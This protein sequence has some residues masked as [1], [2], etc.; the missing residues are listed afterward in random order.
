MKPRMLVLVPMLLL[1]SIARRGM[2]ANTI[3]DSSAPGFWNDRAIVIGKYSFESHDY[4]IEIATVVVTGRPIAVNRKIINPTGALIPPE[5]PIDF[6]HRG[7]IKIEGWA[8]FCLIHSNDDRWNIE[9]NGVP[10]LPHGE[11][12]V[13]LKSANDPRLPEI[14]GKVRASYLRSVS[15]VTPATQPADSSV[16]DT[17][18]G[19]SI[20]SPNGWH[21]FIEP[22]GSGRVSHDKEAEFLEF[23][24]K[25]FDFNV[26]LAQSIQQPGKVASDPTE[27]YEVA[28]VKSRIAY[29][30]KLQD[31]LFFSNLFEKAHLASLP[32]S[33]PS[34]EELWSQ[35]PPSTRP[36][37]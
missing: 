37:E 20:R 25:T 19:V 17:L 36:G 21:L 24:A 7:P 34:I 27:K 1:S 10:C 23:P 28:L 9:E 2:S 26:M 13:G 33:R 30:R 32:S 16:P 14:L 12:L 22:D 11:P 31:G 8:I 18:S 3:L 4:A 35:H 15:S 29:H 5:Q 6:T